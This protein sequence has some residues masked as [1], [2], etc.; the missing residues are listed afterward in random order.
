P[1]SDWQRLGIVRAS[2]AAFPRPND[3][4]SLWVPAGAN[5][6]AFLLLPNFRDIN[7]YNN[8]NS[9]A[10]AVGHLA[11][12]LHGFGSSRQAWPRQETPLYENQ[13]YELQ[14]L[15]AGLGL[16]GGPIDADV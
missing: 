16:Y 6:P 9:Y 2:G 7:R 8:A 5:G 15:L 4:A 14:R 1:V 11:D 3:V 12:R 10:L 13:R